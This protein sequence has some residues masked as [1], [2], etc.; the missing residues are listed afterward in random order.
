MPALE[1]RHRTLATTQVGTATAP[2]FPSC[3]QK[4]SSIRDMQALT[5]YHGCLGGLL[6]AGTSHLFSVDA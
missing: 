1:R 2:A 3:A 4:R 6:L 5:Q